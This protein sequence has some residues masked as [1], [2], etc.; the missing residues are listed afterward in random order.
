MTIPILSN[1][2][3]KPFIGRYSIFD[4]I[5]SLLA[6]IFIFIIM[7]SLTIYIHAQIEEKSLHLS[8]QMV[9]YITVSGDI[10]PTTVQTINLVVESS[11][12]FPIHYKH[13]PS[14]GYILKD[15]STGVKYIYTN[16]GGEDGGSTFTRYWEK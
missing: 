4:I 14:T 13:G 6:V 16:T 2:L 12:T 10:D 15:T 8:K 1:W 5:K 7:S 11:F 9:E 3:C